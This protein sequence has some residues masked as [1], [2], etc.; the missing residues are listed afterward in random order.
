MRETSK[1]GCLEIGRPC[2]SNHGN[3]GKRGF[4]KVCGQCKILD[5]RIQKGG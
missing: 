4:E 5:L 3:Q 1:S 2:Q